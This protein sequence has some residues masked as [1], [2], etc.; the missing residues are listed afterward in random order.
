MFFLFIIQLQSKADRDGLNRVFTVY[1][2]NNQLRNI[3]GHFTLFEHYLYSAF[4]SWI[5]NCLY[6]IAK[7]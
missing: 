7:V 5:L 3:A 6:F 2:K 4:R 1:V